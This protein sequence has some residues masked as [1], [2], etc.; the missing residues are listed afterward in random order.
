MFL[1]ELENYQY[2]YKFINYYWHAFSIK[3]D[4]I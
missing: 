2:H 3:I 4:I 1:V